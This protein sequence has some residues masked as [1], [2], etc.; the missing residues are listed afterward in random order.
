MKTIFVVVL[1]AFFANALSYGQV[2]NQVSRIEQVDFAN[3]TFPPVEDCGKN[4]ASLNRTSLCFFLYLLDY[5]GK[6]GIM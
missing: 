5:N 3:F 1:I 6:S 2:R 4:P